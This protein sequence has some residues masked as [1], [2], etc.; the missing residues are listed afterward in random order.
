M[1]NFSRKAVFGMAAL[2][3]A[4]STAS[5]TAGVA[6]AAPA[7]SA[8]PAAHVVRATPVAPAWLRVV[9][10][11]PNVRQGNTGPRVV[12]IQFLLNA[13][14]AG[15][16]VDGIFGPATA[17]AVRHFQAIS[18]LAVDGVVGNQTWPRLIIQVQRGSTGDAVRAV[19]F[20]LRNVYGFHN[21]AVD[22]IFGPQ[23]QMAVRIFQAR[24]HIGVDGIVGP[25]TWNTIV[26]NEP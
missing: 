9:L 19:Q 17:A 23:T 24:F 26:R 14:G 11:W 21:L 16:A 15:L 12:N 1:G 8:A 20:S 5:M 2:L 18:G 4:A 10:V 22:G 25:V 6:G 7:S 3:T 13:R